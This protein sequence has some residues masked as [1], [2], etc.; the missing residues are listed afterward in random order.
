MLPLT[1]ALF[2][3]SLSLPYTTRFLQILEATEKPN[4]INVV[5]FNGSQQYSEI[6][7]AFKR[8]KIILDATSLDVNATTL[9]G[10]NYLNLPRYEFSVSSSS[11]IK[12]LALKYYFNYSFLTIIL[13]DKLLKLPMNFIKE[14]LEYSKLLT[15]LMISANEDIESLNKTM[16][17]FYTMRFLNVLHIDIASFED[18]QL[19]SSFESFPGYNLIVKSN[20][21]KQNAK[22]IRKTYVP[23]PISD[24]EVF[25]FIIPNKQNISNGCGGIHFHFFENFVRFLNGTLIW[26][27]G[28]NLNDVDNDT[29]FRT[30]VP[31]LSLK[32]YQ[33]FFPITEEVVSNVLDHSNYFIIIPKA[34][35]TKRE[36]YIPKVFSIEIWILT[37]AFVFSGSAIFSIH[38]MIT[39]AKVTWSFWRMFGQL[40]R[41]SLAQPFPYQTKFS[42]M[43]VLFL[44]PILF[45]FILTLWFNTILG[46]F[47]TSVLYEK[48]SKSFDDMRLENM[49][50][51]VVSNDDLIINSEEIPQDLIVIVEDSTFHSLYTTSDKY[52][53]PVTS[54]LWHYFMV[55]LMNFHRNTLYVESNSVIETSFL[56]IMYHLDSQYK[57]QLDRFVDLVKD[58]G[59]YQHWCDIIYLEAMKLK[60]NPYHYIE[61]ERRIQVMKLDF[62]TY[63]FWIWAVGLILSFITFLFEVS[64]RIRC[65]F[66]KQ[67]LSFLLTLATCR[68]N[69]HYVFLLIKNFII[70][71]V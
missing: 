51:A 66:K 35:P 6:L 9:D 8:P 64:A 17:T 11:K 60:F 31:F 49:K 32:N 10:L 47:T 24:Q 28:N 1:L 33:E 23:I 5:K 43:S 41:S 18:S 39:K 3:L 36:L 67:F 54:H 65:Y 21:K 62:F 12:V 15:V 30:A 58:T 59:L 53:I 44:V 4:Y 70:D 68:A 40:F 38:Q 16:K 20:F 22:N 7:N 14:Y 2:N 26:K 37:L 25:P 69:L 45:G 71:I 57:E 34:K 56:R 46:S 52:A 61:E 27:Y 48:Q 13:I 50:L 55:P 42:R 29:E 19:L 63:A